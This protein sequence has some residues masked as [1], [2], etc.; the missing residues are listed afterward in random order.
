MSLSPG[1]DPADAVSFRQVGKQVAGNVMRGAHGP[2]FLWSAHRPQPQPPFTFDAV[3]VGLG[4]SLKRVQLLIFACVR[5]RGYPL[6]CLDGPEEWA[7]QL[8]LDP[9]QVRNDAL[10]RQPHAYRQRTWLHADCPPTRHS[11]STR[12]QFL[13]LCMLLLIRLQAGRSLRKSMRAIAAPV[14]L[15]NRV[16]QDLSVSLRTHCSQGAATRRARPSAAAS[17]HGRA[18][19]TLQGSIHPSRDNCCVAMIAM[20]EGNVRSALRPQAHTAG[21]MYSCAFDRVWSASRWTSAQQ[22]DT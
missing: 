1:G 7:A 15:P 14:N 3:C 21:R 12:V 18:N 4:A 16:E 19:L 2:V 6:R 22:P 10:H 9:L 17:R 8:L 20:S 13:Q 11:T 5:A